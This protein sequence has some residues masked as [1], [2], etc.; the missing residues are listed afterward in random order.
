MA[1]VSVIVPV[2]H[3]AATLPVLV[4]R[5]SSVAAKLADDRFEFVFVDDG[6]RDESFEVLRQLAKTDERL[7]MIRLSRNFGPN[8]AILAGLTFAHGDCAV[9]LAAD[10]QDPP[11]LVPA[12]LD[13]WRDGDRVVFTARRSRADSLASRL[14]SGMFNR[15]FRWLVF[16]D[17]PPGGF[18]FAL[19][20]RQVMDILLELQEKNAFIF[21]QL[22]WVGFKRG[23]VHYDRKPRQEG[24]SGWTPAKRIK[25]FIDAFTAFSYI[26]LRAA[27][28]LGM[29]LAGLGFV[30]ALAIVVARLANGTAVPGWASLTVVVLVTSGVQLVLV[31]ILGEYLWRVLD[32]TRRRPVFIVETLVNIERSQSTERRASLN[33]SRS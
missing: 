24:R 21:G 17:F 26:P 9:V 3:N 15:L 29:S 32:E 27:S 22:L 16:R 28:V 7:R 1:L 31:G 6:S 4:D 20:D 10:L 33:P 2:Y 13:R 30:Y 5:L 12:M 19:I 25:Y 14:A 18:G 11:E 8:A 23:V